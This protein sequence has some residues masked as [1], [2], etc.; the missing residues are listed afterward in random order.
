MNLFIQYTGIAGNG[1]IP[2]GYKRPFVTY[3]YVTVTGDTGIL[4]EQVHFLEGRLLNPDEESYYELSHTS[5]DTSSLYDHCVRA[6]KHGLTYGE[7]G[8]PLMGTGDWNDGMD[9]VGKH[10]HVSQP[11]PYRHS[12]HLCPLRAIHVPHKLNHA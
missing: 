4:D 8:L 3:R 11:G 6:I 5:N 12:N 7:H 10:G 1:N 9:R 2:V